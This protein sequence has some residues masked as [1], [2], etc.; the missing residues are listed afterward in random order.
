MSQKPTEFNASNL[1]AWA[2]SAAKSAPGGDLNALNWKTPDGISVKP[3][4]TAEDTQHL[5]YANTLP[6][7]EPFLRGPQATMY[8]VRPW[9]IRQY[10]GFSTAEESNAFYRKALAAGG[11]GVSVAF[12]LATHRGYD[13]DHPRVTGDVGKAGVAIDSVE[14]MKILFNEIPLDKVSVSMTMNGAVLP[15]LAGYVVAA[16][17]QGV[18]QDK[19]SGT[20]Q[21]DILK[22]FM[23]RNTYIY[24]PEPSMKI[25]GD[26]IGYTA[27]HMPKFN[28]ISISGYHMQEAGANQALELAFTLADGKEYV[29]TAMASGLDVDAFAPRLSFFW[30]VGMNFYL[31][32]A[33]MRAARLLWCRIMKGFDAQNPKSLML[34][35]H[36]QTSGWSLT[37]QDPYNNVVRTTIE[38]MAAVF[39][40]TQSL[41]TNSFDEAIALP[42]EFSSRIARNTQ[43]IIQEETHI[44]NVIDPWAGSY[45]MESLTQEMADKAWAIIEEVETMGGMTK[46]VDSGWAKLK[47]EAAAAE[48]QARIDSGKDVIVGVNKYK[49]AKEDPIDTLDIDNVRVRDGQIERLKHIKAT[50]DSAGVQAAL[51]ALTAAAESGQGNLLDLTIQAMRLRATVGEVSDALEKVFGRH[52]ADT[53]KV[54]GVYAAAYDSASTEGDTMAYWNA[55]KAEIA[56]F[57]DQQGRR[58]RVMIAKLGQDGHDRGAKVV[59]TAYADLGF[60]VDMGPLFQTPEECARQAIENDVHA[61]GV[62]TLAA[63]HKTLVPAIIA[64]L[65]KQG[66]DDIIVFV[67]GVIPRQDYELLYEQGVK[68]IYGPG[69]PIPVSAKDVLEQIKKAL[70]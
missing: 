27:Q 70:G 43:L 64:E 12:D 8:A 3:L 45:M 57:A 7:F 49:L 6:G 52:R 31:E 37:E 18:S 50:R 58:P 16:E 15:V 2:K 26:I 4:Y 55:L 13:S 39:G 63:G 62:S 68:G 66:A 61:V 41:H 33:K 23:V 14:D 38:A 1:Q 9:T 65:K 48:K 20:I 34:R 69:T 42:T 60:D 47:I 28:S 21:N 36:S 25:I 59:A 22:E 19:L 56:A 40:G 5:P 54:T 53:Q 30:A 46:A 24:P 32:I 11:Q 67:G 44:T 51:D 17:E 29:K 10:A 35:T